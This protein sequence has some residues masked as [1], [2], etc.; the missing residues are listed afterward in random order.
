MFIKLLQLPANTIKRADGLT[1][2]IMIPKIE[3]SIIT[4]GHKSTPSDIIS[5]EAAMR[6]QQH[7]SHPKQSTWQYHCGKEIIMGKATM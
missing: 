7:D 1:R 3:S 4:R 5:M 2:F 6:N